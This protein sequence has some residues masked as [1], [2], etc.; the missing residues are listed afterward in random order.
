MIEEALDEKEA[1]FL[2]ELRKYENKWVA[3]YE[4]EDE[5]IVVGSGADAVEATRAAEEK[6]FKDTVLLYVRSFDKGFMPSS[7]V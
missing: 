7:R 5:E 2:E 4:S 3:I 1:A 6:G